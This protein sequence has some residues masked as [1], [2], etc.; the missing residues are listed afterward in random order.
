MGEFLPLLIAIAVGLIST[1][2]RMKGQSQEN[3]GKPMMPPQLDPMHPKHFEK[4]VPQK[5]EVPMQST[6]E[7]SQSTFSDVTTARINE[8][9]NVAPNRTKKQEVKEIDEELV[10]A[11]TLRNLNKKKLIEGV[12]MAEVLGPPRALKPLRPI[13]SK[14]LPK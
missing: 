6:F 14:R 2:S 13:Y 9:I 10:S 8:R 12:M 3:K 7:T 11:T 5:R 1:F 4:K